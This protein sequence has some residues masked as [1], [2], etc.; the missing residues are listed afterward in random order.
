MTQ[1][2]HPTSEPAGWPGG[3][4]L[5]PVCV[6]FGALLRSLPTRGITVSAPCRGA[7]LVSQSDAE[8]RTPTDMLTGR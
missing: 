8:L 4:G 7:A 5:W 6:V 2:R 1:G 3:P